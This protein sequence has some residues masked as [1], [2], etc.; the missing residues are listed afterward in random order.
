MLLCIP[1]HIT[2]SKL[3]RNQRYDPE[4]LFVV[5]RLDFVHVWDS[6]YTRLAPW[7]PK[8][9]Y[10]HAVPLGRDL[11]FL[12]SHESQPKDGRAFPAN[13]ILLFILGHFFFNV[14]LKV[15]FARY[16]FEILEPVPFRHGCWGTR[17]S[18]AAGT[19]VWTPC[20]PA[21]VLPV[22]PSTWC[23][24]GSKPEEFRGNY[25]RSGAPQSKFIKDNQSPRTRQG[26]EAGRP[27]REI[28]FQ[29]R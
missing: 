15:F 16:F 12:S 2:R 5:L 13:G 6:F 7:A 10:N 19:I 4:S 22:S 24:A 1:T 29:V 18:D 21:P 17:V 9:K 11:H 27:S 3:A 23:E 20:D 25:T 26:R 8:F 28:V 14:V